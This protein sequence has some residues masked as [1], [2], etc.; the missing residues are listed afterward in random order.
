M[1]A[2]LATTVWP[3]AQTSRLTQI[4]LVLA[5]TL[6]LALSA[7][8]QVPFW[9]VP[10]TMQTFVVLV[11]GLAYGSRL[12]AATGT[13]YLVQGAVGL[14]VFAKGA[15]LAYLMGP[16]GGYLVGFLLAMTL[17]G[18][19]AEK[20]W[21]SSFPK[22]MLAML[23]GELV[24][25]TAGVGWLSTIVGVDKALSLGLVPFLPAELFKI[26][27]AAVTLPLLHARMRR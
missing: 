21:A 3:S 4:I 19:L 1:Q 18:W 9:P 7:K 26:V 8:V 6:L 10:M 2:T 12:A 5:G 15:G 23:I 25:F 24:I 17:V 11:L 13:L 22:V 27:L 14:P 16:T 20:G